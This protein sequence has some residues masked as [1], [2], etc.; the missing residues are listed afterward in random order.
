MCGR[1]QA[2]RSAEEVARWCKTTGPLPNLRQRYNAAPTQDLGVV[3]RDKESG[4]RRLEALRW[5][6]IPFW[7]NDAKIA[8]ST[9]N[10]MAEKGD[11]VVMA[12]PERIPAEVLGE[13]PDAVLT[14]LLR[15]VDYYAPD[16]ND[17]VDEL[18]MRNF[19]T[20]A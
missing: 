5:G 11:G 16:P 17:P 2:S 7:A 15:M 4:E 3:L 1:F 10:A 14:G 18:V 9:I 8:Y 20:V 19:V 6:L 13:D 12:G